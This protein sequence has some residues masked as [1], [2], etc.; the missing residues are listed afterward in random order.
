MIKRLLS[1]FVAFLVGWIVFVQFLGTQEDKQLRSVLFKNIKQ[2]GETIISILNT[3]KDKFREGA[4][5]SVLDK[6]SDII[7]DLRGE[8]EQA[9]GEYAKKLSALEQEKKA[10]EEQLAMLEKQEK[11]KE[12]AANNESE[13]RSAK[14]RKMGDKL[15]NRK[16]Q[17]PSTSN[18]TTEITPEQV[19]DRI[20]NIV[21]QA[22]TLAEEL[23]KR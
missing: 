21:R 20:A 10:L 2:T 12:M 6:L 3:E 5:D 9:G 14:E 13:T 23:E 11:E 16:L 4:Y 15:I 8:A 19:S 18:Y 7:D 22:N 1:L 17:R